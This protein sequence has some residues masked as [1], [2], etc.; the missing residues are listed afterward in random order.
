M[1]DGS[2]TILFTF[3][4]DAR[5]SRTW[6]WIVRDLWNTSEN[7]AIARPRID[8][9]FI[10][11]YTRPDKHRGLFQEITVYLIYIKLYKRN[12]PCLYLCFWPLDLTQEIGQWGYVFNEDTILNN[13]YIKLW[14]SSIQRVVHGQL[15]SF[16]VILCFRCHTLSVVCRKL[17]KHSQSAKLLIA[18]VQ[19][20]LNTIEIT[21][22]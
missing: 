15:G 2:F 1:R 10:W 3:F 7:R 14:L 11:R 12:E 5:F 20:S 13:A 8:T 18:L 9:A 21:R 22:H 6:F 19:N 16:A 17:H 4:I